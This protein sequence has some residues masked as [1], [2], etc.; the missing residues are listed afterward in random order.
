V[1]LS[2]LTENS[3]IDSTLGSSCKRV[4]A[5]GG[6][7]STISKRLNYTFAPLSFPKL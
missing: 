1:V 7:V 6:G 2:V 3:S 5:S 4:K